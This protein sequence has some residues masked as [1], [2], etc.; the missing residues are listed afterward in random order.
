MLP[1]GGDIY[2]PEKDHCINRC[3][4]TNPCLNGGVC[5]ETG[6]T[7]STRFNC[8]CPNTYSGQRCEKIKHPRSCKDIAK[9]GTSKSGKYDIYDSNNERFS[10]Y[11]DLQSEPGFIWTFIQSFS[12]AKRNVFQK[13]RF[14]KNFEIDIEEGEVNRTIRLS[15]SQMQSLAIDSTHQR[16]TCNF[17]TDGLR[18]TDYARA[19][20]AGH[21]IFGAW[22]TCQM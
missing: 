4:R 18:Y 5:Q 10:V 9:N 13:A 8:T 21:D 1:Y 15:L 20:L 14:G 16:A 2:S 19:K 6:D 7:Y 3:R 17:L 22:A 11:C 12:L